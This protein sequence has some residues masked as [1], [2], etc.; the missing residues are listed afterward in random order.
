MKKLLYITLGVLL[1][2]MTSCYE[3]FKEDFEVSSLYFPHQKPLRTVFTSDTDIEVGIV[4]GG[5]RHNEVTELASFSLA[6]DLL[7]DGVSLLPGSHYTMH[8]GEDSVIEVKSG[9]FQGQFRLTFTDDFY[10]DDLSLGNNY[11]LPI[12]LTGF[13]TDQVLAGKDYVLLM[14][15]YI[16]D[17]HGTYYQLGTVNGKVY[18]YDEDAGRTGLT[19]DL[20]I[21]DALEVTTSGVNQVVVPA[22][23]DG[24]E[25]T[26]SL[27][28]NVDPE[29]LALSAALGTPDPNVQILNFSGKVASNKALVYTYSY[30]IG[31][32]DPVPVYDS[33]VFRDNGVVFETW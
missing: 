24:T 29:S 7:P 15:K 10:V 6:P 1:V 9:E 12:K 30:Q 32:E 14:V 27:E 22:I 11:V 20:R 18:K 28:L 2:S 23:G 26:N 8:V 16:N 17:F 31:T 3:D 21:Y 25:V 33:L 5:K 13:T 4:L 19:D